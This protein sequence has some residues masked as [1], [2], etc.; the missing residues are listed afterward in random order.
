MMVGY[1]CRLTS[2]CPHARVSHKRNRRHGTLATEP[3]GQCTAIYIQLRPV[4]S[5]EKHPDA[6]V[7]PSY[8][9]DTFLVGVVAVAVHATSRLL[10]AEYGRCVLFC[11]V[12]ISVFVKHSTYAQSG[13]TECHSVQ[14]IRKQR[15]S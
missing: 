7:N 6:A 10:P 14:P 13:V 4:L 3:S 11:S 5:K 8:V 9:T 12:K 1:R 2:R 15:V